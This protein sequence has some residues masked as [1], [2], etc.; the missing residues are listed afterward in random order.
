MKLSK[1]IRTK[2]LRLPKQDAEKLIKRDAKLRKENLIKRNESIPTDKKVRMRN[3]FKFINWVKTKHPDL[4]SKIISRIGNQPQALN[5]LGKD[6][7]SSWFDSFSTVLNSLGTSVLQYKAQ[8]KLMDMQMQ[9]AQSGLP[10]L[11]AAEY[12]PVIRTQVE[13]GPETRKVIADTGSKIMLPVAIGV[14]VIALAF[15]MKKR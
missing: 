10:P 7:G 8:K 5:G 12:A 9:R 3:R 11:Q 2:Y 14:G 1:A 15:L 13:T 4:Y 6:S